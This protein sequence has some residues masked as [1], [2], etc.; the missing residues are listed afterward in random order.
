MEAKEDLEKA[1]CGRMCK[2]WFEKERCILPIKIEC[3]H[4]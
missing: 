1:G 3:Q 2:G 4:K